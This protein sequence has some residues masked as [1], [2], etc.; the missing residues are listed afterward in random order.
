MISLCKR[1]IFCLQIISQIPISGVILIKICERYWHLKFYTYMVCWGIN[2]HCAVGTLQPLIE[3]ILLQ[4]TQRCNLITV[5]I[6]ANYRRSKGSPYI[7]SAYCIIISNNNSLFNT[8]TT[9]LIITVDVKW[10][11]IQNAAIAYPPFT[12]TITTDQYLCKKVFCTTEGVEQYS[13]LV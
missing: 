12:I 3:G 11:R 6:Y 8:Y 2:K 4:S 7:W 10:Y 5:Q 9:H 13:I 1:Y